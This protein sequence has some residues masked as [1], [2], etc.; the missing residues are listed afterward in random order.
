M[1]HTLAKPVLFVNTFGIIQICSC[2]YDDEDTYTG[3]LICLYV[4]TVVLL[5]FVDKATGG[6]DQGYYKRD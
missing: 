5:W 2:V 4:L 6:P 1:L 3:E